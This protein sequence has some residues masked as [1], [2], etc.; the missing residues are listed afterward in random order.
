MFFLAIIKNSKK[1]KWKNLL[2]K[3]RETFIN[4]MENIVMKRKE[5]QSFVTSNGSIPQKCLFKLILDG[6]EVVLPKRATH[7][8]INK[9]HNSV[10]NPII[11]GTIE[12]QSSHDVSTRF[13][14]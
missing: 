14:L 3:K 9:I 8:I 7:G 12:I 10:Y 4:G 11:F 2:I 13:Q 5:K 6:D 1:H